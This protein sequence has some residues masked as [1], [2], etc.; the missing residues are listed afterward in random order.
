M[1]DRKAHLIVNKELKKDQY[2]NIE[3][4]RIDLNTIQCEEDLVE[5]VLE[6]YGT[7][8]YNLMLVR[9]G[10]KGWRQ[11]WKGEIQKEW[12]RR[13]KGKLVQ[14]LPEINSEGKAPRNQQTPISV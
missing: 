9:E 8:K 6:R 10:V 5:K 2:H 13:E 1:T 12:Y 3:T 7:G 11:V 14:Y 4:K